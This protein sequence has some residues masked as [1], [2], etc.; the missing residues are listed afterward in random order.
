MKHKHFLPVIFTLCICL[1]FSG[2][3]SAPK[4]IT[5]EITDYN[6]QITADSK[7]KDAKSESWDL[8]LSDGMSYIS[9]MAYSYSDLAEGQTPKD[10]YNYHND[11]LFSRR[12]NVSVIEKEKAEKTSTANVVKTRFSAE[13]DSSKNYYDSFLFEFEKGEVFAWVLIS[14]TPSYLE[15]NT[16][17]LHNIVY[18]LTLNQQQ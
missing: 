11:D 8:Q 15:K 6:L 2:C 10:L 18:S 12:E 14:A 13:K 3:S 16:N 9:V 17:E 5:H 7:F 1:I 4:E